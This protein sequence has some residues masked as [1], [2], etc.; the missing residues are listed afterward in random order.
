MGDMWPTIRGAAT[1]VLLPRPATAEV[2]GVTEWSDRAEVSSVRVRTPARDWGV[3]SD[4]L[5]IAACRQGDQ[6]A[7][8]EVFTRY[9]RLVRSI[10][11]S[12]GAR[13]HDAEEIVQ[14]S[15]SVL[16]DSI[17][18]IRPDSTLAPWL[19]TIARRH[20]WRLLERRRRAEPADLQDDALAH[21]DVREHADRSAADDV[22]R[23]ALLQM[24]ARCRTLLEA[25]YLRGDEPGYAEIARE[26]DIPIGS[27]G[28][29]RGRCLDRLRSII[30]AMNDPANDMPSTTTVRVDRTD[31]EG[32][33]AS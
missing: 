20:T 13:E 31:D 28:P 8:H 32:R 1:S 25:L 26:L 15:F 5:L 24:P 18:T 21:D 2:P 17:H 7:W 6:R 9:H 22:L 11:I 3:A 19:S 23:A 27:I 33:W 4:E 12:Y 10:A 16:F 30:E 29:T 14:I